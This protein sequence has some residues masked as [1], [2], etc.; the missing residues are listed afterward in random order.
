MAVYLGIDPGAKGALCFLDIDNRKLAFRPTPC[1]EFSAA[2]L[3]K[4]VMAVNK[5]KDILM[6]GIEDVHAIHG[7]SA[8]S[9]FKFG[10]NVGAINALMETTGIGIDKITPKSWQNAVK[11]PTKKKAGGPTQLKKAIASIALRLY[12]NAELLGPRGGVID[13]RADALMIA[14]YLAIKY[15]GLK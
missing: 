13:G 2:E 10:Y 6:I 7:T 9:N 11:V 5:T 1:L 3:R 12:P 15:G 4:T 8:G 14:H